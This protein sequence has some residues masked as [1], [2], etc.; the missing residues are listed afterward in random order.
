MNINFHHLA[1]LLKFS[2]IL[3]F[4]WFIASFISSKSTK[5]RT[6]MRGV[7]ALRHVM[8]FFQNLL[9]KASF[10]TTCFSSFV[11]ENLLC[12]VELIKHAHQCPFIFIK[13]RYNVKY[14]VANLI[15]ANLI[16]SLPFVKFFNM[17][18]SNVLL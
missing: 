16:K 2:L 17:V 9:S 15:T 8:I 14:V 4:V 11:N 5:Q 10:A 1:T 13:T 7:V 6:L 3:P 12:Y 18:I